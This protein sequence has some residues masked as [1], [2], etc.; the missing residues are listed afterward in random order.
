MYLKPTKK[1]REQSRKDKRKSRSRYIQMQ[2]ILAIERDNALCA[3]CYF[4]YHRKRSYAEV[5]HVYGRDRGKSR[6]RENFS[7]L[8]C[9]CRDCHPP[10]IQ[11]PGAS[12][13]LS[14]VEDI[15]KKANKTPIKSNF[16]DTVYGKG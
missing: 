15:L 10:P 16:K 12:A 13:D 1:E 6:W 14:W 7:N 9:V 3:I 8:L 11:T 2:A 5:H 4:K